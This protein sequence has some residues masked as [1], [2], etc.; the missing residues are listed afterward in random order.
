MDKDT[1]LS[2]IKKCLALA[3][4]PNPHEAAAAMR[5]AQKLMAEYGLT[6]TDVSLA[7]VCECET[8][9]Q[10]I[11]LVVWETAL[12]EAVAQAFGCQ[13]YTRMGRRMASTL[14][15]SRE[16]KFVFVGVGA[17]AEVAGYAYDVLSRQ[18]AK[19]RRAHIAAQSKNCKPKTKTARGDAFAEG[20]VWGVREKLA[21]FAGNSADLALVQQY[22]DA[23]DMG[24]SAVKDR[25]KGKNISHNDMHQGVQAGKAA[26]LHHGVGGKAAQALLK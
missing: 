16:R 5:Q 17:A 20:W 7:D 19:A 24:E 9:A 25:S 15:M 2:K 6:E 10:T 13:R 3:A 26:Q 12:S 23:K 8:G 22:M 14:R 11:D 4:S 1:A 21:E 18:C